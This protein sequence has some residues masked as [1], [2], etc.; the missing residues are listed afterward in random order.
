MGNRREQ[1]VRRDADG[2]FVMYYGSDDAG[3]KK[4]H[5]IDRDSDAGV[6]LAGLFDKYGV[7]EEARLERIAK[8]GHLYQPRD[9]LGGNGYVAR[10]PQ[11]EVALHDTVLVPVWETGDIV[12]YQVG[13]VSRVL[14]GS[15]DQYE[16]TLVDGSRPGYYAYSIVEVP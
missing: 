8:W 6:M 14:G 11:A 10:K 2:S 5:I 9:A 16:V 12:D 4:A 3:G 1:Y 7:P 15:Y 13:V